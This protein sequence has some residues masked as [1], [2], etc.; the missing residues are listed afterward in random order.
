VAGSGSSRLG[1]LKE[2][3]DEVASGDDGGD[4]NVELKPLRGLRE[5]TSS[6]KGR[7]KARTREKGEDRDNNGGGGGARPHRYRGG[8]RGGDGDGDGDEQREYDENDQLLS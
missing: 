6:G 7:E 1:R 5:E 4:G 8:D 3:E 2:E